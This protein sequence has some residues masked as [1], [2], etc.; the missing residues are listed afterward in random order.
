MGGTQTRDL[1]G[2][3]SEKWFSYNIPWLDE[4]SGIDIQCQKY[5]Y[6]QDHRCNILKKKE[7]GD[8]NREHKTK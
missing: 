2:K 1:C 4:F 5:N 3:Q 7:V 8:E 6:I